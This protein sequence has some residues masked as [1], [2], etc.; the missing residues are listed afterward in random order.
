[1]QRPT[2]VNGSDSDDIYEVEINSDSEKQ[3]RQFGELT[4]VDHVSIGVLE[5]EIWHATGFGFPDIHAANA[6]DVSRLLL[7]R[8][9]WPVQS[10]RREGD[11]LFGGFPR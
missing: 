3:T 8:A 5:G 6:S 10:Q 4:D 11:C 1:M 7:A 9:A 2:S